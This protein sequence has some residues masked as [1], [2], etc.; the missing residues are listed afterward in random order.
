FSPLAQGLLTDKYLHGVPQDS[1]MGKTQQRGVG[2]L[3]KERLTDARLAQ[4]A[5]L[6]KIA[7]NRGQTLA[8]LA[9]SW[10]LADT[11]ITSVLIGASSPAQIKENAAIVT[12]PPLTQ[13]ELAAIEAIC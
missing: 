5:A 3:P 12:A 8:Q 2:F 6:N 11:A 4:I 13:E 9:L 7:Q 1:R 10:V